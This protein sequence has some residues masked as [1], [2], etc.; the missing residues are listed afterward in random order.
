VNRSIQDELE[1]IVRRAVRSVSASASRKEMIREELLAHVT[2]VFDEEFA[3]LGD[4]PAAVDETARRFGVAAELK[5]ELQ[6]SVP[7][8]ER[9]FRISEK[10]I[11]MSRWYWLL[12]VFAVFFGP[13]IV[14]PALA[15]FKQQ[16]VLPALEHSKQQG[17]M[18]WLPLLLGVAITLAGIGGVG[19]GV[20]RRFANST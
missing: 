11:L 17:D 16:I 14:L 13:A 3:R 4:A 15:H 20:I 2:A 18:Q 1:A 12:A 19:Y 5:S 6:A 9:L 10:E 7:Y 8:L